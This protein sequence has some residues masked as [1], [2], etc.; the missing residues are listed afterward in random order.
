MQNQSSSPISLQYRHYNL[1][2]EFP[3]FAF[4]GDRWLLTDTIY[5]SMH[6]HNC[7]EIGYCYSGSGIIYAERKELNFQK[8]DICIIPE[9]TVHIS[10][11]HK[12]VAS[13]WEYI[14]F[15]PRLMFPAG[16]FHQIA[17]DSRL[18][19]D[20]PQF[21]NVLSGNS[22]PLLA[23]LIRQMFE[24]FHKQELGYQDA[25]KGLFLSFI[26]E[27]LRICPDRKAN[28]KDCQNLRIYPA[29]LH[30]RSNYGQK[31]RV[32]ELAGLCGL[33][34]PHFRRVFE[35]I[36]H[37]APLDYIHHLRIR[38]ACHMLI[39]GDRQINEIAKDVGF[40]SLS[41]FNRQFQA[42]T[43]TSPRTWRNKNKN[44]I[45]YNQILSLDAGEHMGF[46]TK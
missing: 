34:E 37:L 16:D 21:S 20:D 4:L 29:I 38:Q 36:I 19:Y 12:D 46:F 31:I 40:K 26:T 30:I 17:K 13:R 14:L 28:G 5:T 33:S 18:Y 15:D 8:G 41:S 39:H 7:M 25:L 10:S 32:P 42:V 6:F 23:F 2:V 3:T 45:E 9:N 35:D 27:Y 43:G 11:S 1:P 22:Q 24:E 44:S